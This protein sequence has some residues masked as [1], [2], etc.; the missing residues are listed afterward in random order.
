MIS[1]SSVCHLHTQLST[2][3][4]KPCDQIISSQNALLMKLQ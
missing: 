3:P 4:E 2:D 1:Q